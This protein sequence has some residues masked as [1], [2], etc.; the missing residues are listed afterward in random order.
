MLAAVGG[1]L[2]LLL[3]RRFLLFLCPFQTPQLSRLPGYGVHLMGLGFFVEVGVGVS[4]GAALLV[5]TRSWSGGC[6]RQNVGL[7]RNSF[8]LGVSFVMLGVHTLV[9]MVERPVW[10]VLVL[11]LGFSV[12]VLP[13]A[14]AW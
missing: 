9:G 10:G 12:S 8:F 7:L 11:A 3:G 5:Y 6:V 2:P 4:V 13:L 14:A 1:L